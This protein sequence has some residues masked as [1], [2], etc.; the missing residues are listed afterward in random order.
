M[1]SGVASIND[2]APFSIKKII[3]SGKDQLTISWNSRP[4]LTYAIDRAINGLE[5]NDWEELDDSSLAN[6][7]TTSYTDNDIPNDVRSVFY[8]LDF[9]NN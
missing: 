2:T 1:S 9:P 8:K 4:G 6:D 7:S 3:W 5:T